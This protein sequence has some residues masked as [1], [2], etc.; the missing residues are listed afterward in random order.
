MSGNL[1][2]NVLSTSAKAD[3]SPQGLVQRVVSLIHSQIKLSCYQRNS[4]Y[5]C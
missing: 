2:S 3:H 1:S 5:Q 4:A